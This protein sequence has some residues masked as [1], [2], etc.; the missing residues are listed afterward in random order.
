LNSEHC[1]EK[2]GQ[3]LMCTRQ[4]TLGSHV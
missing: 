2:V 3:V 4:S 1:L